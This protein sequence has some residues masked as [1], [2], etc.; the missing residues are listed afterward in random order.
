MGR[1]KLPGCPEPCNGW[2]PSV[3]P[4]AGVFPRHDPLC[5]L[6]L[7]N[8][9][10][11]GYS[12]LV[13]STIELSVVYRSVLGTGGGWNTPRRTFPA[14]SPWGPFQA[15]TGDDEITRAD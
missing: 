7:G 1:G 4:L 14:L 12:V 3:S 10:D 6:P 13:T 2:E 9:G 8:A 11:Q 5:L 15:L